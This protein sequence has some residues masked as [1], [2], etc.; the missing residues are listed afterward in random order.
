MLSFACGHPVA[1]AQ[2]VEKDY[3]CPT[4]FS[5]YPCQKS[6]EHKFLD[7]SIFIPLR[8]ILCN[9]G[10]RNDFSEVTLRVLHEVRK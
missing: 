3:S 5:W 9:I 4:E 2:F 8:E 1:S 7:S 6:I 10:V